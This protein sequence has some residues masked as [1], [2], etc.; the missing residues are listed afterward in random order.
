MSDQ[1]DEFVLR[2]F[3]PRT[4]QDGAICLMLGGR[5]TGK[6]YLLHDICWHKRY[7]PDGIGMSGTEEGSEGLGCFM[8]DSYIY[9]K[10]SHE[11][12]E[13]ALDRAKR[14]N[15]MRQKA[16]LPKKFTFIIVDDC[17]CDTDFTKDK[18]LKEIMMNGR[19]FGIFF[20]FTLQY[21][22]GIH[23]DLRN[24]I[25]YVFICREPILANR[26]RLYDSYAGIIPSFQAFCT[27]M[28][29]ATEDYRCLVI[30]RSTSNAV[31]DNVFWYK[32][33]SHGRFVMGSKSYWQKHFD[34]YDA[35]WEERRA[36]GYNDDED[37]EAVRLEPGGRKR[38]RGGAAGA[39]GR[40][41]RARY[42]ARVKLLV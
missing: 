26:K 25:D 29:G 13:Q 36:N 35:E 31:E 21:S 6:T 11:A 4:M 12:L 15:R 27:I 37:E 1:V 28:D 23:P 17:G 22:L 9:S 2:K 32:A 10:F 24:Q 39:G 20:I 19:H 5:G 40:G 33:E 8:P 34:R 41:K 7:L 14:T 42:T 16:G 3:D 38:A 18:I 30:K